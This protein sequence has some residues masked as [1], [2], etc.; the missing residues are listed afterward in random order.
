MADD[1]KR[2]PMLDD[3]RFWHQVI[4][5]QKRVLACSPEWESRLKTMVN[6]RGLSGIIEVR[7]SRMVP[8]DQIW[9]IDEQ[10]MQAEMSKPIRMPP[11][12]PR[13][14]NR[15]EWRRWLGPLA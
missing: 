7:V 6:A 3:I 13:E 5:D 10:G 8:D 14:T 2:I 12:Y 1:E 15:H 9:S 4:T 11:L